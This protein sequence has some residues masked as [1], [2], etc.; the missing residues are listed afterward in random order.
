MDEPLA[1]LDRR[2][3]DEFMPYLETLR[4]TLKIPVLYVT[5]AEPEVRRL[6]ARTVHFTNGKATLST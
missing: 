1:S 2:R 4:D 3:K 6:A 5:H